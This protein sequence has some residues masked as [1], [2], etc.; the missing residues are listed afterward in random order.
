[1]DWCQEF[2]ISSFIETSAKTSQNVNAAFLLAVRQ[3]QNLERS[4]ESAIRRQGDTIDLTKGVQL[5]SN[6]KSSCCTGNLFSNSN[7]HTIQHETLQ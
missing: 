7:T 2:H 3:W 1:M 4:T 5:N 6:G